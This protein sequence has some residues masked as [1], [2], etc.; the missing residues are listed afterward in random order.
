MITPLL[1]ERMAMYMGEDCPVLVDKPIIWSDIHVDSVI[2]RRIV[3]SELP[4]LRRL[5][6]TMADGYWDPAPMPSR[7]LDWIEEEA[8]MIGL[9]YDGLLVGCDIEVFISEDMVLL[10]WYGLHPK[11]RDGN[12]VRGARKAINRHMDQILWDQGMRTLTSVPHVDPR[13]TSWP[14]WYSRTH[15]G[16]KTMRYLDV[17][18]RP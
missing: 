17:R 1:A 6:E 9:F 5:V 7:I 3:M 15:K 18:D 13:F 12:F 2:A 14:R 16:G 4:E 8:L 10:E 11:W